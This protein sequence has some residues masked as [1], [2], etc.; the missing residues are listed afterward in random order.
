[1]LWRRTGRME[2]YLH[3]LLTSALD[4]GE[5]SASRCGRFTPRERAPYTHWRGGWVVPTDGLDAVVKR[6]I[7]PS[8]GIRTRDR[9]AHTQRY[10][11]TCI[12]IKK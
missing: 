8:T 11:I 7:P 2:V 9:R 5:W 12:Y 6:K 4:G 1:M 10:T 3:A